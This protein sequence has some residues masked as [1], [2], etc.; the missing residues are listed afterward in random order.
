MLLE[1]EIREAGAGVIGPAGS[2]R[3][4]LLLI[5]AAAEGGLNAAVLDFNLAGAVVLPV[6]DHLAALGIPF[7]FATGY[8][9]GCDRR[10]HTAMPVLA[11]PFG[12]N[13]LLSAL[14]SLAG[15]Q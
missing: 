4:A 5:E 7:L 8:G 12:P 14:R 10:L 6:A 13:T 9:E 11:K 1:D 3:E 2:V 15:R